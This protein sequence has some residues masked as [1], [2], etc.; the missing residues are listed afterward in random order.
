[1]KLRNYQTQL[2]N[3]ARAELRRLTP[4]V[5]GRKPRLVM[6]L[7]CGGGKTILAAAMASSAIDRGGSVA[8][9]CH[10]DFL[11]KQSSDTFSRASIDHSYIAAGRWF[12]PWTTC[13]VGM[14]GSMKS[15]ISKVKAPSLCLIDEA[16]HCVAEPEPEPEPTPEPTPAPEPEPTPVPEPTP[17][18]TPTPEIS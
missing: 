6:Q 3:D 5:E 12:N 4:L 13:H 8:F 16:H 9:L 10:R 17:E 11:L 2:I 14:I 15:R 7:G 18:P 1:M